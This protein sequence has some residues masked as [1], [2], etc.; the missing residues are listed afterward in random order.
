MEDA[1]AG[2]FHTLKSGSWSF[3]TGISCSASFPL[4]SIPSGVEGGALDCG[5]DDIYELWRHRHAHRCPSPYNFLSNMSHNSHGHCDDE[6]HG[7]D[8]GHDHTPESQGS[9]NL[10]SYI[11]H[12]NVRIFNAVDDAKILK[13]WDQRLD[14]DIVSAMHC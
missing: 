4:S 12:P 5:C 6:H 2:E 8:H 10:Y 13:P 9:D 1:P 11:D 14:E 3:M 7:H